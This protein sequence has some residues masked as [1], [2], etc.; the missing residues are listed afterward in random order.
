[1]AEIGTTPKKKRKQGIP[2]RMPMEREELLDYH[3]RNR[4]VIF[5][6]E[7]NFN[8]KIYRN[9]WKKLKESKR[10]NSP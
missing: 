2:K 7:F 4:K 8:E 5:R 9:L 6:H 3:I 1:M 10:R